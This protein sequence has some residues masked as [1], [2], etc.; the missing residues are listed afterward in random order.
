MTEDIFGETSILE[1][2]I[3]PFSGKAPKWY[4]HS[5]RGNPVW[6]LQD[7]GSKS[8]YAMVVNSQG[9]YISYVDSHKDGK[10]ML[11]LGAY[12]TLDKAKEVVMDYL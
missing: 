3:N 5:S 2:G 10:F 12:S 8:C 11:H 4:R 9:K 6:G 7:P 1:E